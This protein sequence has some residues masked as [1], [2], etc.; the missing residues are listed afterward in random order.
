MSVRGSRE[1]NPKSF[2]LIRFARQPTVIKSN[3]NPRASKCLRSVLEKPI[4]PELPRHKCLKVMRRQAKW[5]S[6]WNTV[7]MRS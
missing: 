6:P 4:W 2:L 3:A 7:R 1:F 5:K